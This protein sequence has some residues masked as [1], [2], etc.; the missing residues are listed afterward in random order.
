MGDWSPD[1]RDIVFLSNREGSLQ[2]WVIE[3]AGGQ[4]RRVSRKAQVLGVNDQFSGPR[5]SPDGSAIGFVGVG[6]T[7]Q[8]LWVVDPQGKNERAVLP[9][10]SGFDWYRDSR[11]VVYTRKAGDASDTLET[12]VADLETRAEALL[13][14]GPTAEL[15]VSRDGSSLACV[16][17]A[18]HFDMQLQLLRLAVPAR[19]GELPRAIG[20][21]EPLTQGEAVYHVHNGGWSPDGRAIVYT[22]DSDNGDIFIL[23]RR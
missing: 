1:G 16:R 19:S 20:K 13:L 17:S 3:V 5:W 21:P 10:V 14:R 12:R 4:V 8:A 18:S 15:A 11:I 22:R 7:E 6:Q 23:Q 9:A 2:V